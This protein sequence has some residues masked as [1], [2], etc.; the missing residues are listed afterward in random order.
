MNGD[1]FEGFMK[2]R[3]LV[4]LLFLKCLPAFGQEGE[5]PLNVYYG[6]IPAGE[7]TFFIAPDGDN[8]NA[9]TEAEP[10]ATLDYAV[11]QVQGGDVIV[12]RGGVY[13]HD[14]TIRIQS[15]SGFIGELIVVTAYPGEVPI[16]DF[17]GQPDVDNY[18]GIRLNAN[19]WHLIG[20][21][22]RYASHNGIRID[23]SYNILEQV[24]AYGNYDTGIHMAGGALNNLVKNC[25]SFHNF[26][27]DPARSSPIGGDAD[28]FSAKFDIGPGNRFDGNR[29]WE[30]SDDGFDFWE[31]EGSIVVENSWAFG[32][33]DASV[34]GNPPGYNGNGNGFKLGGNFVEAG[35]I[36]RRCVAFGNFGTGGNA[37][38]FD[39]NN[40]PGAM[41]LIHNTAYNN[42]RNFY[43]PL[44][45][46]SGG[47]PVFLNNLSVAPASGLDARTPPSALLAG[48]SWQSRT[49]LTEDVF[50]SVDTDLAKAP[51]EL[52]GSLPDND[53]LKLVPGSFPVDSGVVI[54][55]P[56]YGAAL[57]MGAYELQVG[58]PVEPLVHLGSGRVVTDLK[59]YDLEHA[60]AWAIRDAME[61]GDEPFGGSDATISSLPEGID[62][63]EWIQA[64]AA[65][66]TKNYLFTTAA[67]TL[68]Q[69]REVFVAHSDDLSD[70]PAWLSEFEETDAK[71]TITDADGVEHR[72]SVYRRAVGA[73]EVVTLGR[74]S[75][76]G[77]P[78]APMYFVMVGS[79][80]SVSVEDAN[81]PDV[82]TR[83]DIFPNPVRGSA[84]VAFSLAGGSD[85]SI[86]LYD[87][88]GREVAGLL[89]GYYGAG[90]HTVSWNAGSLSSG[91]YYCRMTADSVSAVKKLVR[92]RE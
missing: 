40:N 62:V 24:T 63:A 79:T 85:V 59:V 16:L 26:D 66:R 47:Q 31:A 4:V 25:D 15:P 70:K 50:M 81:G 80:V 51:R 91:V 86:T 42:G 78:D 89:S 69:S 18:H 9:G 37:K 77:T 3:V 68:A 14:E 36:V 57:D 84:T 23:G 21:T 64:A 58:A 19:W 6:E 46:L 7:R 22:L 13:A 12:M 5:T 41:T 83:L 27:D 44:D 35:H 2:S 52:D 56:F 90:T 61:V 82:G 72:M 92:F 76:D 33:G 45:P 39:Y 10:W 34:F 54:G 29:A 67:F 87:A 55:E 20:I 1:P 88:M 60:D 38:G 30:N 28:G 53:F 74:N 65:T 8:A 71:L 11:T 43:F 48:N 75:M 17:S 49:G 73:G 32:N